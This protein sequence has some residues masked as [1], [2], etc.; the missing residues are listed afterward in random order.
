MVSR[1]V[2]VGQELPHTAQTD[3]T[4][5]VSILHEWEIAQNPPNHKTNPQTPG[6]QCKGRSGKGRTTPRA[7]SI[8]VSSR[9]IQ[10][11]HSVSAFSFMFRTVDLSGSIGSRREGAE[12]SLSTGGGQV[13]L[14]KLTGLIFAES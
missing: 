2:L 11:R 9:V 1:G 10:K 12:T 5:P 4:N 8:V 14:R 13:A 6:P 3:T 7:G